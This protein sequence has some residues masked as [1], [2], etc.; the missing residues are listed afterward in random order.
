MKKILY[1][2]CG[3]N[4]FMDGNGFKIFRCSASTT[5]QERSV[6]EKYLS[7]YTSS[8]NENT[9][10]RMRYTK[11]ESVPGGKL[12]L[13]Q[14]PSG[15]CYATNRTGN[16]FG[17]ALIDCG[18][19][20]VIP[21]AQFFKK[22]VFY[23]IPRKEET[24]GSTRPGALPDY[25]PLEYSAPDRSVLCDVCKK[26]AV[27][28]ELNALIAAALECLQSQ[29]QIILAGTPQSV[30]AFIRTVSLALP[31]QFLS[32]LTFNT[33]VERVEDCH[34]KIIG[35][36][37]GAV[38]LSDYMRNGSYI[39]FDLN[40][41]SHST[42]NYGKDM[43]RLFTDFLAVNSADKLNKYISFCETYLSTAEGKKSA[44]GYGYLNFL[45]SMA[46]LFTVIDGNIPVADVAAVKTVLSRAKEALDAYPERAFAEGVAGQASKI[47]PEC[48]SQIAEFI[49][50]D[51]LFSKKIRSLYPDVIEGICKLK[52]NNLY[53]KYKGAGVLVNLSSN[54]SELNIAFGVIASYGENGE[55]LVIDDALADVLCRCL[56]FTDEKNNRLNLP[57]YA[58]IALRA[59]AIY[60]DKVPADKM[61]YFYTKIFSLYK[62]Y[63]A[64]EIFIWLIKKFF[65]NL[66]MKCGVKEVATYLLNTGLAKT[67]DKLFD[68]LL[69]ENFI[70]PC[71]EE[72]ALAKFNDKD[73]TYLWTQFRQY[74]ILQ[75][76]ADIF[77]NHIKKYSVVNHSGKIMLNKELIEFFYGEAGECPRQMQAD[78]YSAI[79]YIAVQAVRTFDCG[80]LSYFVGLNNKYIPKK[81]EE[82]NKVLIIEAMK[83][84]GSRDYDSGKLLDEVLKCY[85]S[86]YGMLLVECAAK[87]N[88][89]PELKNKI[90]LSSF[91]SIS[92][93]F[94]GDYSKAC[95]SVNKTGDSQLVMEYVN[96]IAK[97]RKCGPAKAAKALICADCYAEISAEQKYNFLLWAAGKEF[98]F[99]GLDSINRGFGLN[100][101]NKARVGSEY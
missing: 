87:Y 73:V 18:D 3:P 19:A 28:N 39:I 97:D 89:P 15:M 40:D 67:D 57:M 99:K 98:F 70:R 37:N 51:G 58:D 14:Q 81:A 77:V 41:L 62:D 74:G 21:I 7:S 60:T 59:M 16:F 35:V 75:K 96:Y 26:S 76:T 6:A 11:D 8:P 86:E 32:E 48:D 53:D 101:N 42:N 34:D 13:K 66:Q 56:T 24:D 52:Y 31:R 29:R 69:T 50:G 61:E 2:N 44:A 94:N 72:E 65:A 1:T 38:R 92:A 17:Q 33:F 23:H 88:L 30:E 78:L 79:K 63:S 83:R 54:L 12:Y 95:D 80:T 91:D 36:V 47:L 64:N 43:G 22:G 10:V 93:K 55:T 90:Y 25:D 82:V 9:P 71:R 20:E 49:M 46:D 4:V 84:V 5:Q 68:E 100:V 27:A 85:K 45:T